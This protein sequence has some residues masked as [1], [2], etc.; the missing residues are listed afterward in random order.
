MLLAQLKPKSLGRR[1][2][3]EEFVA[4]IDCAFP[5]GDEEAASNLVKEACQISANACF[6]VGEELSRPPR[7]VAAS[8]EVRLR[9]LALLRG[10]FEHPIRD[11]V[12][13]VVAARISGRKLHIENALALLREVAPHRYQY[14]ALNIICISCDDID[15]QLDAEYT[16]IRALWET[17]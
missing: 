9:L 5:Y 12:L 2:A 16:R 13:D 7:G 17:P 11:R 3:E 4:K 15:D 8:V 6:M 1:V 14:C 10:G